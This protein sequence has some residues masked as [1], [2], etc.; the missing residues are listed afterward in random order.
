[1]TGK[2]LVIYYSKTGNTRT[3]AEAIAEKTGGDLM[4]INEQGKAVTAKDPSA[5]DLVVIGTPVNGFRASTPIQGYLK[6]NN[7][8]LP[9][10]ATYA[11]YSLWPAG[12]LGGMEKLA[13]KKP[14]ASQTFKSADIKLGRIDERVEGFVAALKRD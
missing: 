1:M 8:K 14:I 4:E 13:G 12:T 5:Y 7:G 2:T 10:V 6:E 9:E 11:T 3:V